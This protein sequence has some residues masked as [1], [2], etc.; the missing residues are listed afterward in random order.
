LNPETEALLISLRDLALEQKC[1]VVSGNL[2]EAESFGQKRQQLLLDIEKSYVSS[3][4]E[5]PEKLEAMIRE[6]MDIDEEAAT[7]LKTGMQEVTQDLE[8]INTY[9]VLFRGAIDSANRRGN[10]TAL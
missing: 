3:N 8:N 5:K 4:I 6:I 2:D 10:D 1:A 7:V 9:R